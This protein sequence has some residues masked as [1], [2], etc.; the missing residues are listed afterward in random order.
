MLK[1]QLSFF[2]RHWGVSH[3]SSHLPIRLR[4]QIV[5]SV[6]FQIQYAEAGSEWGT[7]VCDNTYRHWILRRPGRRAQSRAQPHTGTL[8]WLS[9]W[10]HWKMKAISE[11]AK[12]WGGLQ[13]SSIW[14]RGLLVHSLASLKQQKWFRLENK[15]KCK[16][17]NQTT[18]N[19]CPIYSLDRVLKN[20]CTCAHAQTQWGAVL[21]AAGFVQLKRHA[22]I[23]SGQQS[24][25]H[26]WWDNYKMTGEF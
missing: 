3:S 16:E 20:S 13:H 22:H 21:F 26:L 9:C 4:A 2:E 14:A 17:R 15:Q 7:G 6:F 12:L 19:C 8:P 23:S 5:F 1:A 10:W 18:T 11:L 24:D 25:N